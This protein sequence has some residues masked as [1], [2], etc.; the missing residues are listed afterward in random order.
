MDADKEHIEDADSTEGKDRDKADIVDTAG[1]KSYCNAFAD[2]KEAFFPFPPDPYSSAAVD[3]DKAEGNTAHAAALQA[4]LLC[5]SSVFRDISAVVLDSCKVLPFY[6]CCS[7]YK[8]INNLAGSFCAFSWV[9]N[10][11]G[12]T[13][14]NG[15]AG[16]A[17]LLCESCI[18]FL[19]FR[20]S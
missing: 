20:G 7:Y 6:C 16:A 3:K 12:C 11:R 4:V 5:H 18:S 2:C 14:R 13:L 8:Y 19:S 1:S 10:A 17:G 9:V 15:F